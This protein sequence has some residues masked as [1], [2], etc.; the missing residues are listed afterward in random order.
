MYPYVDS[1]DGMGQDGTRWVFEVLTL[2]PTP[3]H[4]QSHAIS[5]HK[6]QNTYA[7]V[8]GIGCA[9]IEQFTTGGG[10]GGYYGGAGGYVSFRFLCQSVHGWAICL[11]NRPKIDEMNI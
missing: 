8:G 3:Q 4:T 10:G 9:Y 1:R 11:K 2:S 5:S 6:I 7:H